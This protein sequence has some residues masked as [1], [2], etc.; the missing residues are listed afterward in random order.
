M[1]LKNKEN[2]N[3]DEQQEG[4][5]IKKIRIDDYIVQEIFRDNVEPVMSKMFEI[6]LILIRA[7]RENSERITKY[8]G[9]LF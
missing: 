1:N 3:P 4:I 7:N 9:I 6:V 8:F 2:R 5:D